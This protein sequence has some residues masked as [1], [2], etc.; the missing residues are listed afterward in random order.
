MHGPGAA[1]GDHFPYCGIVP[2]LQTSK[3]DGD[4]RGQRLSGIP[5][6]R[7]SA[8]G[9][10]IHLHQADGFNGIHI[11]VRRRVAFV[12]D[13]AGHQIVHRLARQHHAARMHLGVAREAV[14]E[15]RHLER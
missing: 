5:H 1:A 2:R 14:Q 3:I 7:Q 12:R 9:Q 8:L 4:P 13:E 15:L 10:D 11:E 6:R